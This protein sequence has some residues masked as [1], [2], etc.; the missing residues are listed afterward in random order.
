MKRLAPLALAAGLAAC[1][2]SGTGNETASA[3]KPDKEW[4]VPTGQDGNEPFPSTY[5][6][7]P[8]RPTALVGA[9]VFDGKGEILAL[10]Q[11]QR[12]LTLSGLKDSGSF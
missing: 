1:A 7:Y 6:P 2:T 5:R 9:T 12:V 11:N 8:G 4:T 3:S 10:H